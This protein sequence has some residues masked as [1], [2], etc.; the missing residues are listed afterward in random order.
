[1]TKL[2]VTYLSIGV[3]QWDGLK[4]FLLSFKP[5]CLTHVFSHGMTGVS[6]RQPQCPAHNIV[7]NLCHTFRWP[8]VY[9]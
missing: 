5:Q 1:M 6:G 9:K 4:A 3:S 8:A 7:T 2:S